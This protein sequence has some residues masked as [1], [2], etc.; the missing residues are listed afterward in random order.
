[1]NIGLTYDLRSDYLKAG[2][3]HEATAEFDREDTIDAIE[4]ALQQLGYQTERIG[5]L[6]QLAACLVAGK[7]WDL[8]FN[9]CEGLYGLG[10]EAQVPALLDAY[11]IS[12]VFSDV[13]VTALTLHKGMT[14]R[15]VR[16]LGIP[17]PDFCVVTKPSEIDTID[18]P[19][20][21]FVKPVAEG[22]GKGITPHSKV[23]SPQALRDYCQLLLKIY[24]QPVL[25][26]TFLPGREFTV[27]I[28]GTGEDARALAVIEVLLL[29]EAEPEV[30]SYANK[31][32]YEKLINY[33]LTEEAVAQVCQQTALQA[34]RGLNCRDA[35][36]VDLRLDHQGVPNF[37]EVNPLAGLHPQH[38]DLPILAARQGI[39]YIELI[40]MIMD[41]AIKRIASDR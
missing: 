28:V 34:W 6:K 36:R 39:S 20:P 27:G 24:Q 37:L 15:V 7:R 19:Y 3:S 2:Y 22:S 35:G 10:R 29:D 38:S 8:I 30:Y 14:K 9:I 32:N 41:S 13:L 12:Y 26:E 11:N 1:M 31:E 40:Q 25:V 17:T 4:Q 33:V 23:T 16:D 18:L 5:H 21:L